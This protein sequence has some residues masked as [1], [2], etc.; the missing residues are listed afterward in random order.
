MMIRG[1][2]RVIPTVTCGLYLLWQFSCGLYLPSFLRPAGYTYRH[3][4][5][6]RVIPTVI[7]NDLR[8]IPTVLTSEIAQIYPHFL[9]CGLNLPPVAGYTYRDLRVI[10]TVIF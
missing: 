6:L 10:T 4:Y 2:L 1:Q 5:D 3:F 7:F 8:V 9:T